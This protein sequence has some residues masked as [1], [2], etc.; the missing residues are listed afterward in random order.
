MSLILSLVLL[1]QLVRAAE[2][3]WDT[4]AIE[5]NCHSSHMSLSINLQY[6][7][8]PDPGSLHLRDPACKPAF[9]NKT[10]VTFNIPLDGCGTRHKSRDSLLVFSNVLCN[11]GNTSQTEISREPII[12]VPFRCNYRP[13]YRIVV[14]GGG[15]QKKSYS[16]QRNNVR[17]GSKMGLPS[18]KDVNL[19]Q[20]SFSFG[21]RV[22]VCIT[23]II[24]SLAFQG[25][26]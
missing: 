15:E 17:K 20:A 4:A 7:Q 21:N 1:V 22:N 10:A 26:P 24:I 12:W 23:S 25:M 2:E 18:A 19:Q 16:P 6:L 11:S 8:W 5:L 13:R 14:V 3:S 9:H